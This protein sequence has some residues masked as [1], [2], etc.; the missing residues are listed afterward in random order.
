MKL[1]G[2]RAKGAAF[3][4]KVAK[5]LL[6]TFRKAGLDVSAEDAFR[7]PLSGGHKYASKTDPGDIQLSTKILEWFPMVVECKHW[8][9]LQVE[10]FLQKPKKSWKE[11]QWLDQVSVSALQTGRSPLLVMKSNNGVILCAHT[12]EISLPSFP[13]PMH[14]PLI[15]FVFRK[16]I[17]WVYP[18][19]DFLQRLSSSLYFVG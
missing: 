2:G 16:S 4:R 11:F 7:T 3:E 9:Q 8:R 12:A 13:S 6:Q 17:W 18:F 10:R 14:Q 19:E 1:G 15:T 5:L